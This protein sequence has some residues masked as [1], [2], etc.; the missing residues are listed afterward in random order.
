MNQHLR[1][2]IGTDAMRL[3]LGY[4]TLAHGIELGGT[5]LEFLKDE[6]RIT[7]RKQ[8]HPPIRQLLEHLLAI[9]NQ[10]HK[11][12]PTISIPR[13]QTTEECNKLCFSKIQG[14]QHFTILSSDIFE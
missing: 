1:C 8:S 5:T 10:A 2:G 11:T 9:L 14:I 6:L 3:R 7:E 12:F 4:E 13:L